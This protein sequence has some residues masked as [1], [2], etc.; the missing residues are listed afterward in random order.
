LD[1]S[2]NPQIIGKPIRLPTGITISTNNAWSSLDF[3]PEESVSLGGNRLPCRQIRFKPTGSVA[4]DSSNSWIFTVFQHKE[5]LEPEQ[6]FISV[7]IDPVT[8]RVFS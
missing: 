5:S 2:S 4:L 7:I 1:K 3:L 8:G 6:N